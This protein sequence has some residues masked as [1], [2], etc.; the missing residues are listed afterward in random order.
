MTAMHPDCGQC[1]R[2]RRLAAA[3]AHYDRIYFIPGTDPAER[4]L[5]AGLARRA[6]GGR[7]ESSILILSPLAPPDSAGRVWRQISEQDSD[8]LYRLYHLYEFS[9]RFQILTRDQRFGG[10]LNLMDT[11]VLLSDELLA[12]LTV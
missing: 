9:D 1:E 5:A 10:L 7:A 12:A 3:L 11:G 8:A 6:A 2:L 4:V